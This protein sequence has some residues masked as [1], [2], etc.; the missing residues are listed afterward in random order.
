MINLENAVEVGGKGDSLGVLLRNG[1]PIPSGFV[2][3]YK[4]LLQL[5]E[6]NSKLGEFNELLFDDGI[7]YRFRKID[8]IIK[9]LNMTG[10]F[11][12]SLTNFISKFT[13]NRIIVRS[14]ADK[15]DSET[16]SKAG[17][18]ESILIHDNSEENLFAA[19]KACW[20][21][22][23]TNHVYFTLGGFPAKMNLVVQSYMLFEKS[24][25]AFS[26]N[27]T[28]GDNQH[29]IV[30]AVKGNCDK[31]VDGLEVPVQYLVSK[32]EFIVSTKERSTLLS[33]REL[34]ELV[35]IISKAEDYFNTEV[36]VEWGIINNKVYL[37]QCRPITANVFSKKK[38]LP[39]GTWISANDLSQL[40]N[41][42]LDNYL[43]NYEHFLN[44]K[45]WT[46][47][48]LLQ[49]SLKVATIGFYFYNPT[50]IT[51]NDLDKI[52]AYYSSSHIEI[53]YDN[54][55][56]IVKNNSS[57]LSLALRDIGE[58]SYSVVYLGEIIETEKSG[59]ASV[60]KEG[61]VYIEVVLGGFQGMWKA[62]L[63][64]SKYL[65]TPSGVIL[66]MEVNEFS[67]CSL[68]EQETNKWSFYKIP[69][70]TCELSEQEIKQI[71]HLSI[72]LEDKIGGVSNEWTINQKDGVIY[73]DLS[74]EI[75]DKNN[76]SISP[77][78][79]SSGY[80]KSVVKQIDARLLDDFFSTLHEVNV[81]H[82]ESYKNKAGSLSIKETIEE[83]LGNDKPII[84]TEFPNRLLAP[85]LPYVSG[86]IFKNGALLCHL[87]IILREN[88]IPAVIDKE[89]FE[90]LKDGQLVEIFNDKLIY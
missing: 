70:T 37:V 4:D 42:D 20:S 17:L 52:T 71:I 43:D 25:V 15:E 26:K 31:L 19:I 44:K 76:L 41:V 32:D 40:I 57:D 51:K 9:E 1:F 56:V 21:S 2:I 13:G 82:T 50:L 34:R 48:I 86:C 45:Y 27:I 6:S 73:F 74:Q 39:H 84:V 58:S 60:T 49:E 5:L 22:A 46:R 30:E 33:D 64:P 28:T 72:I 69:S 77:N 12:R 16:D 18:F 59:Y 8:K 90:T 88:N 89:A 83:V 67:Q 87:S 54:Q 38:R 11:K 68:L 23:Y 55:N 75:N 7:L 35:N 80:G 66:S 81:V 79:L 53:R 61:N 10:P 85:I 29:F 63:H 78:V 24:G 36:D 65:V 14:S 3:E 62:G 47:H